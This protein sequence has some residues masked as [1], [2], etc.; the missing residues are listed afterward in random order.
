MT[1]LSPWKI[2]TTA[3]LD[4]T[5]NYNLSFKLYLVA[6]VSKEQCDSAVWKSFSP[7]WKTVYKFRKFWHDLRW[8]DMNCLLMRRKEGRSS[9]M[10]GLAG[11]WAT[12]LDQSLWWWDWWR[13]W[14][15]Q[16]WWRWG[17]GS[18]QDWLR[19]C[20]WTPRR[21]KWR[22]IWRSSSSQSHTKTFL[23]CLD[24]KLYLLNKIIHICEV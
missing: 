16:G 9:M 14:W 17:W 4:Q 13:W 21:L 8:F 10:R 11:W 12:W 18:P 2:C 22:P 20:H 24:L 19:W 1:K 3:M 5:E 15:G 7:N 6:F 23:I